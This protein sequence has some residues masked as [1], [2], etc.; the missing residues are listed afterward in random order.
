MWPSIL[1]GET[2]DTGFEYNFIKD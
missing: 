1:V 2:Y